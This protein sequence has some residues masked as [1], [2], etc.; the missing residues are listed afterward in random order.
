[1][2]AL[3]VL[4]LRSAGSSSEEPASSA[5]VPP[6]TGADVLAEVPEE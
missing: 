1:M 4:K 3:V 2:L 6:S 5:S